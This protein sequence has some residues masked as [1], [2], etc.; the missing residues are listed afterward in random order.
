VSHELAKGTVLAPPKSHLILPGIT[1]DVV[2]EI[3]RDHKLPHAVRP[4]TEG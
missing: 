1:Y 2:L 4:V 3:L